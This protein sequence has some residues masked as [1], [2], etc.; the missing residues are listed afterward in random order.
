M[1]VTISKIEVKD[2]DDGNKIIVHFQGKDKALVC[3]KTNANILS[4]NVGSDETDD[5]VGTSHMLTVKKV[6]FQGRLVPAIRVVL[7]DA[8]PATPAKPAAAQVKPK[9]APVVEELP[10]EEG[11]EGDSVPF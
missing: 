5:W 1:R 4:E 6:E 3:N 11:A 8:A 9:P 7:N 10:E 2:F